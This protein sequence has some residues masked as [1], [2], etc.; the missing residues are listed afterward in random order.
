MELWIYHWLKKFQRY[1]EMLQRVTFLKIHYNW[2][3]RLL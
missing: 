3:Y 1:Q 2:L